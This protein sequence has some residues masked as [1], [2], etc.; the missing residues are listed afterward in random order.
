[1]DNNPA[2]AETGGTDKK[3]KKKK[4]PKTKE[5]SFQG[6]SASPARSQ[7]FPSTLL[8]E[9]AISKLDKRK[10]SKETKGKKMKKEKLN[11]EIIRL[12]N[13]GKSKKQIL[14]EILSSDVQKDDE[15]FLSQNKHLK[16]K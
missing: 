13:C 1:M 14:A 15:E 7:V 16:S 11:H 12:L 10:K 6:K 9:K 4:T 5:V 8:V 3:R 2:Q